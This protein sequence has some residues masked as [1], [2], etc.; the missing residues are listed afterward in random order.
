MTKKCAG[1]IRSDR[2]AS[3]GLQIDVEPCADLLMWGGQPVWPVYDRKQRRVLRDYCRLVGR[4]IVEV[5]GQP[6][7]FAPR[8]QGLVIGV[9]KGASR[10]GELFAHLTGRSFISIAT[11]RDLGVRSKETEVILGLSEVLDVDWLERIYGNLQWQRAPGII[12]ARN[13]MALVLQALLRSAA[14]HLDG[15]TSR[16]ATQIFPTFDT[17]GDIEGPSTAIFGKSAPPEAIINAVESGSDLLTLL[18]HS[19]G[20]D[21]K[22]SSHLS[23]CSVKT[24]HEDGINF[25]PYCTVT[26]DCFRHNKPIPK[27]ISD[28]HIVRPASLRARIVVLCACNVVLDP[29]A[30]VAQEYGYLLRLLESGHMGVA[31][32]SWSIVSLNERSLRPLIT[33]LLSGETV[34]RSVAT[35]NRSA[36]ARTAGLKFCILGDANIRLL[37]STTKTCTISGMSP[38][39]S[40]KGQSV[41][42]EAAAGVGFL[43][44]Y[45]MNA[46]V[47]SRDPDT[48]HLA[49]EALVRLQCYEQLLWTGKPVEGYEGSAGVALRNGVLAFIA[50]RGASVIA[51]DW[52]ELAEQRRA[53]ADGQCIHCSGR[54][55]KYLYKFRNS[56]IPPR[57][58]SYCGRCHVVQDSPHTEDVLLKCNDGQFELYGELP[59]RNWAALIRLSCQN[60]AESVASQW[61]DD[62]NG[63]PARRFAPPRPWPI[64][65]LKCSFVLLSGSSLSIA[66]APARD[67]RRRTRRE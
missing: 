2:Q 58:F 50:R 51:H 5:T 43:R 13:E 10:A 12:A 30:P 19:D 3:P 39:R 38:H 65:P 27:A 35:F 52:T 18:T 29:R 9:G 57:R 22:I 54:L 45:L 28:G 42:R 21:A 46:L 23:L 1:N 32:V 40:K 60:D 63:A 61:P 20:V 55:A 11:L 31:I 48:D 4:P 41:L 53:L 8:K 64:G 24:K 66:N 33:C 36:E 67:E 15:E 6:C 16:A 59:R 7:L 56:E 37:E 14:A 17:R 26:G 62:S 47:D 25:G 34:G 49:S 44:G